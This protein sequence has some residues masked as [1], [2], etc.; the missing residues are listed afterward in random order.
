[1]NSATREVKE[2]IWKR[3]L[4]FAMS[5]P[6]LA[7]NPEQEGIGTRLPLLLVSKIFKARIF[8]LRYRV[9]LNIIH[10]SG[11]HCRTFTPTR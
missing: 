7:E 5:V 2:I 4:Y 9:Q 3:I 6:Q 11:S 10:C 1:M 8:A